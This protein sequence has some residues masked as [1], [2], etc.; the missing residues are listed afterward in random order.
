MGP[1]GATQLAPVTQP[2][3]LLTCSWEGR[4]GCPGA[5]RT[6]VVGV[7]DELHHVAGV[8]RQLPHGRLGDDL[9]EFLWVK[10]PGRE[11]LAPG[12]AR[13]LA[14]VAPEGSTRPA[15]QASPP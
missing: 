2:P 14:S 5:A 15:P 12:G 11:R 1:A 4:A 13:R 3:P 7:L 6:H 8:L 9:S 10:R